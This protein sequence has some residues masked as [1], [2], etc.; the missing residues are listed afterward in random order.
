MMPYPFMFE[1][2]KIKDLVVQ[3]RIVM[4][5]MGNNLSNAQGHLTPRA[6]AYYLA[7]AEGGVGLIITE[8]VPVS[9]TGKHRAGC[10]C[11]FEPSHEEGMKRLTDAI[12]EAGS[13]VAIQLHHAGRLVNPQVSGGQIVSASEI[14]VR[15]GTPIPQALSPKAIRETISDFARAAKRALRIGF[16]AIE[17]HGGHGY[18][19]HQFFSSR[20]NQRTDDF[21]GSLENRMQFPLEVAKAV[22]EAV[23]DDF[24]LIFR[25][26]AKEYEEGGY[27][28]GEALALGKKLRD[29]GVDI[30]HVSA[31]TTEGPQSSLY[32][33]QPQA[34]P[35]ACLAQFAETF[36]REVGL[37]VIGV[38]R[39]SRPETAEQ[40]LR[41][42]KVDL[43]AMGRAL[44]ADPEWTKKVKDGIKRLI[45]QC[46]ACNG[47][48]EAITNQEPITCSVNPLT[49]RE[50]QVPFMMPSKPKKIMVVG[51]GPAG[52]E[53]AC[54]AASLG[55]RVSLYE[56]EDRI[57]GQLWAASAPPHKALLKTIINYY[58][59]RLP[60][61][62]IEL[63]LG[64]DVTEKA[65]EGK[66][67]D[68][69]ILATGCRPI[70][71]PLPGVDQPNVVM[72]RDVLSGL[73]TV[74]ENVLV[75]GG[76]LVGSET[77][78]FLAEQGKKVRLIEEL[79]AV[80][81]DVEPRTRVL[82]L[83][84]LNRL[85][86]ETM[87]CCKLQSIA[88]AQA[89]VEFKGQRLTVPADSVVLAVGSEPNNELELK[90]RTCGCKIKVIG[91][92]RTPGNIKEA[93]HQGF[94]TVYEDLVKE[95]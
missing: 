7:R 90:L 31:G 62:D 59:A 72:A 54:M 66:R 82:L 46:T 93:V 32:C 3:N 92:C 71:P 53:A 61:F 9:L 43:V 64:E 52:L 39:I 45:R 74:G 73:C 49:G 12:H 55:H 40:L 30:L 85:G 89:I 5:S 60:Q 25:I 19:I 35:E 1:P 47:C 44:L 15:A 21:G 42:N 4:P 80:A 48:I 81:L 50:N 79:E 20:S 34:M 22:R 27:K 16:D 37:P 6:I 75:V 57:G 58:E 76:G 88:N 26:S 13:K 41:D 65:F 28:L 8:A 83:E 23:G 10:L 17:I 70:R 94:W 69:L 38:G 29:A 67:P 91:D 78:E 18:L 36:K 14:P 11:L 77:A 86:V 24:P 33:I 2:F 84:R 95:V 51:A 63:H 56:R 68:L 87:T